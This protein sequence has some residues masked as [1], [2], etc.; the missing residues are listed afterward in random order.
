MAL[1][2][3]DF[4]ERIEFVLEEDRASEVPTVFLLRRLTGAELTRVAAL[5]PMPPVAAM[6]QQRAL[7][8]GAGPLSLIFMF[9]VV[10]DLVAQGGAAG[11]VA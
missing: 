11:A 4:D 10:C 9:E 6:R 5:S 1:R 7:G 3:P 8:L 2:L